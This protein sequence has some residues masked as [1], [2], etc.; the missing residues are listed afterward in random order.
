MT[1]H[2]PTLRPPLIHRPTLHLSLPASVGQFA[3]A[4][5][6]MVLLGGL[7]FFASTQTNT[8]A[9][10]TWMTEHRQG[11]ITE[12]MSVQGYRDYR[13]GEIDAAGQ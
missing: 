12:G 6:F 3:W 2:T 9:S 11:E 7:L 5:L 4:V 8:T 1:L 10:G 13:A